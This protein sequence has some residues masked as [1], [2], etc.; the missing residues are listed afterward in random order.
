MNMLK[1]VVNIAIAILFFTF[2]YLQLND[3]N[4]TAFWIIIYVAVAIL[5]ILILFKIE[6]KIYRYLLLGILTI[7]MFKNF[8]LLNDWLDA[9]SPA[10]IDYEPTS[11]REVEG[12]REFL[13]ITISLSTVLVY[14]FLKRNK[15]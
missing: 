3:N 15:F 13:G 1:K 9:G 6:S 4:D 7:L 8:H 12:I 2:A 11:I 5:P 10:F 14:T